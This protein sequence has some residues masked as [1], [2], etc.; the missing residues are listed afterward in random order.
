MAE[1]ETL[2]LEL[3]SAEVAAAGGLQRL[4]EEGRSFAVEDERFVLIDEARWQSLDPSAQGLRVRACGT[5]VVGGAR[6]VVLSAAPA[7]P[8]AA[9]GA[10]TEVLTRREVEIAWRI[11]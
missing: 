1:S 7:A 3:A 9:P 4:L 11:A 10:L 6:Y 8:R 2:A 5:M